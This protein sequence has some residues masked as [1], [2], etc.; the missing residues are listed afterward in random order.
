MTVDPVPALTE[1]L[2]KGTHHWRYPICRSIV[3]TSK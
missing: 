1:Y 2:I 3:A